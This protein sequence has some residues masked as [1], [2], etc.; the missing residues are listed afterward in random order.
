MDGAI[1]FKASIK[2]GAKV[3]CDFR[4]HL[5]PKMFSETEARVGLVFDASTTD[6]ETFDLRAPG[7]GG[8]PYGN[9]S[10]GVWRI[11]DLEMP[12]R[13]RQRVLIALRDRKIKQAQGLQKQALEIL[14]TLPV[15]S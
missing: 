11:D 8:K 3:F 4:A 10:L 2:R 1:T 14:S 13:D 7:Y 15:L 5:W 9:G 12:D 6:C